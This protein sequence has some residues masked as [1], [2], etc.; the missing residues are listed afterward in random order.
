[1]DK[2]KVFLLLEELNDKKN[3]IRGAREKLDKKRKNIVRKQDVSFDNI[4][5]LK[6]LLNYWRNNLKTMNGN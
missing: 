1:M 3:K 2:E 5:E 4:D 6:N